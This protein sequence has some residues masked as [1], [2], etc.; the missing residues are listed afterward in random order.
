M[1]QPVSAAAFSDL[2]GSIYDCALDPSLWP[3]VLGTL[4][5]EMRFRNAVLSL[6]EM[7]SGRALVDVTVGMSEN[8]RAEMIGYGPHVAEAWGGVR[9]VMTFPLDE[10]TVMTWVNPRAHDSHFI[11]SW[12]LP[13]G[14]VDQMAVGFARDPASLSALALGR[15]ADDGPVGQVEVEAMRLF[16]PHLKRALAISR[17]LEARAVERATYQ[18]TLDGLAVAVLLVGPDLRLLH[19]NR[20]GEAMLRSADP[21]ALRRGRVSAPRG[22]AEA[23]AVAAGAAPAGIGRRGL[24]VPA[25]RADGE[26]LVLHV[27]PLG[28]ASRL[29][30]AAAAIF[31][32]PAATPPPPPLAAVAALF[33]LTPAEARVLEAVGAGRTPE[34]AAA[35][36]GIAA[37]TVRTH[38]LRL[39]DKTGTRR[40]ADLAS[41]LASFSLPLG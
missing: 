41:L 15:H 14:F 25:R 16:A 21:L 24:G 8:D 5:S 31:V 10:P 3:D 2:V 22:L 18:E 4:G 6:Q 13:R 9:N 40:Q 28:E 1:D 19:A 30:G 36:F 26:A 7:P 29:A 32:A 33:D 11:R 23:L 17:L 34:E 35:A 39:F 27:L 37:S 38:L 12:A 20:A